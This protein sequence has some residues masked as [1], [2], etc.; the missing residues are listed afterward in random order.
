MH[1]SNKKYKTILK[2][3]KFLFNPIEKILNKHLNQECN[4]ILSKFNWDSFLPQG[5]VGIG[6]KKT[7]PY[8]FGVIWHLYFTL[9]N[10]LSMAK[11][12]NIYSPHKY[13]AKRTV[14]YNLF[15]IIYQVII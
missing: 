10:W 15:Y 12:I 11:M 1:F 5:V 7:T 6:V 4:R 9:H 2:N 13:Y 3:S 14:Y 8:I